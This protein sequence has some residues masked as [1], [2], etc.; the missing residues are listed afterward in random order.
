MFHP[1]ASPPAPALQAEREGHAERNRD[2][3]ADDGQDERVLE[4]RLE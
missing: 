1:A 2:G 4:R 3:D